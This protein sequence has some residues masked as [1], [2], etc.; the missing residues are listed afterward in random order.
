[1]EYRFWCGCGERAELFFLIARIL[2]PILGLV[3]GL[4]L[5]LIILSCKLSVENRTICDLACDKNVVS[6]RRAGL[7]SSTKVRK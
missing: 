5:V 7:P 2:I 4:A 1:M 6:M 3:L